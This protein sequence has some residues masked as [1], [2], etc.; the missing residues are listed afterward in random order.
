VA[1]VDELHTHTDDEVYL[2]LRTATLKRPDS[3]LVTISTAGQGADSPLGRLR[4]RALA[5][6]EL[7]RRHNVL[8][9]ARGPA[10]RMLEW[11]VPGDADIDDTRIV[12]K[13]TPPLD[14]RAGAA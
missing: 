9:D 3:R 14:H 11:A 7:L 5:Q 6:P 4:A 10:L 1:I 8:T 13:A 12:K 2:A